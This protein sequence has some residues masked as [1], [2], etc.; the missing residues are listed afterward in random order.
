MWF[1]QRPV[2]GCILGLADVI[3]LCIFSFS[4]GLQFWSYIL[5]SV[6]F[7]LLRSTLIG[8]RYRAHGV[9][10][11]ILVSY[12]MHIRTPVSVLMTILATTCTCMWATRLHPAVAYKPAFPKLW[13]ATALVS[14]SRKFFGKHDFF[15]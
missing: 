14:G 2:T 1:S 3:N 11:Q 9:P 12:S 8:V 6:F 4:L 5:V 13:V 15:I 7:L 10:L